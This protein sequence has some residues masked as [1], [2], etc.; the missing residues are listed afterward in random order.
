MTKKKGRVNKV[1][2]TS[3]LKRLVFSLSLRH[4]KKKNRGILKRSKPGKSKIKKRSSAQKK[5]QR[6][7]GSLKFPDFSFQFEI[8]R[9]KLFYSLTLIVWFVLVSGV[10]TKWTGAPGLIQYIELSRLLSHK[11]K[12][13]EKIQA[14]SH[15]LEKQKRLLTKSRAYQLNEIRKVLGYA[16]EDELIFDFSKSSLE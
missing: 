7:L 8:K 4:N 14:E 6:F 15:E 10:V 5:N 3:F 16:G 1:K 9:K 12:K 2:K 11:E 13:L